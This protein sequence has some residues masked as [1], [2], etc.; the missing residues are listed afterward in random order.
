MLQSLNDRFLFNKNLKG[1]LC[2]YI[3]L[4]NQ[5]ALIAFRLIMN[6]LEEKEVVF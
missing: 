4:I 2:L 6:W 5:S 3:P 1:Y